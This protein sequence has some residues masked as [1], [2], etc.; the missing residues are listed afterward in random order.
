MYWYVAFVSSLTPTVKNLNGKPG[1][2]AVLEPGLDEFSYVASLLMAS[3]VV[4]GEK[5]GFAK[6]RS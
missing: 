1:G 3:L 6:K 2:V 5:T 4:C